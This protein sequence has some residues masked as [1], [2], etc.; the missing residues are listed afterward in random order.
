MFCKIVYN[1]ASGMQHSNT[2]NLNKAPICLSDPN[3]LEFQLSD[4]KH[5][6]KKTYTV[7]IP[8]MNAII[9]MSASLLLTHLI[10]HVTLHVYHV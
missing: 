6:F 1:R 3:C 5:S 9:S 10:Q 2:F 7:Y 8:Q 4:S